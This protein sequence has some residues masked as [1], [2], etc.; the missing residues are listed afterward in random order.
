MFQKSCVL[1]GATVCVKREGANPHMKNCSIC[2][3]DNVGIY[4]TDNATGTYEDC[5]IARNSLAGVWVK[6]KANPFFRRCHIHDGRDVGVFT[7]EHG[8]VSGTSVL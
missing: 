5:E 6:N 2:G 7:F 4:I 8:M 3:S 1:G